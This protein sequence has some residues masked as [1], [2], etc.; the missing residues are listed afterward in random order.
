[1]IGENEM[2]G[3]SSE[4]ETAMPASEPEVSEIAL[5]QAVGPTKTRIAT[6]RVIS[7]KMDKTVTVLVERQVRHPVYK[8][9][10]KR[11]TK[12]H[13]HD[14]HNECNEGDL[15]AIRE[16]RPLSKTKAWT[17]VEIIERAH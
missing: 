10:I 14:E 9:I 3:V 5:Q 6:G 8:K 15:V 13:A 4:P 2:A 1:M 7:S 16:C 12:I 11:S 17:L